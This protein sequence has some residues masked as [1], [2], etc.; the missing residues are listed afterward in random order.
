ML[1]GLE[2]RVWVFV[3]CLEALSLV[4]PFPELLGA[5]YEMGTWIGLLVLRILQWLVLGSISS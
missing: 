2:F 1:R 3:S 4:D 5:W